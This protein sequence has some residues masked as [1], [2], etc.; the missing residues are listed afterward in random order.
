MTTEV[1][2]RRLAR[3]WGAAAVGNGYGCSGRNASWEQRQ[4]GSPLK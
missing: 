2:S 4:A 1:R 3:A